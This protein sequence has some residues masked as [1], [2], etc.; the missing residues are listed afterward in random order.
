[1]TILY[2]VNDRRG[3]RNVFKWEYQAWKEAYDRIDNGSK[4][5]EIMKIKVPRPSIDLL[6]SA[7]NGDGYA[8][9]REVVV[10]SRKLAR[11]KRAVEAEHAAFVD[12]EMRRH[13]DNPNS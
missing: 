6:M 2:E 13:I 7:L 3:R 4:K 10:N 1:M 12:Y 9:S 11:T 5:V 8:L